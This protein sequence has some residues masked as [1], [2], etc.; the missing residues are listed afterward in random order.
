MR[1]YKNTLIL[2]YENNEYEM[3]NLE[4]KDIIGWAKYWYKRRIEKE[5]RYAESGILV[6][7]SMFLPIEDWK[8]EYEEEV[9]RYWREQREEQDK[10]EYKR[11]SKKFGK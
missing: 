9:S 11:L 7:D 4:K 5:G 10:R 6:G 3:F 8:N 1:E 2:F